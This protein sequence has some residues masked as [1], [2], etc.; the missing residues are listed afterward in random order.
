MTSSLTD[1]EVC[2]DLS[3][4]RYVFRPALAERP[5]TSALYARPH[6][7][8]RPKDYVAR[9]RGRLALKI[10]LVIVPVGGAR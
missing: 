5:R 9:H 6:P 4:Y 2:R 3:Q 7:R 8:P 1:R 10:Q